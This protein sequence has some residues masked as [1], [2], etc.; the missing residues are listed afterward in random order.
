MRA[1]FRDRKGNERTETLDV[2]NI[3]NGRPRATVM[4]DGEP[5]GFRKFYLNLRAYPERI[6]YDACEDT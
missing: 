2:S 4:W 6:V 5:F 1:L 3:I